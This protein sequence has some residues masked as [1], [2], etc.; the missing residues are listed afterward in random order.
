MVTISLS[1]SHAR[2][3]ASL[4]LWF[5]DA[6]VDTID[7]IPAAF[8]K[9]LVGAREAFSMERMGQCIRRFRRTYLSSLE[10]HPTDT[11][12]DYLMRYFL[13]YPSEAD[14]AASGLAECCNPLAQ[15]PALEAMSCA[16]WQAFLSFA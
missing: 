7:E 8:F 13:Y 15:L 1:P 11:L 12:T 6:E 3:L 4:Q 2:P 16:D 5:E 10:K 9:H 14:K